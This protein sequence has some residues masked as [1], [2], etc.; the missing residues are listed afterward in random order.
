L[1]DAVEREP[2]RV[3]RASPGWFW[4]WVPSLAAAALAVAL[5]FVWLNNGDL[6]RRLAELEHESALQQADLLR[7][8]E[9]LATL[10]ATDASRV[11]LVAAKT[12]AQPQGRAIYVRNRGSLIFL[13]NNF[14]P[15]PPEKAYEL[16][17]I[18]PT[19]SPVPVAVFKPDAHG[20]A[21]VV[22]PPLPV[23]IEAKA[24]AITVEPEK[25]SPAPTATPILLGAGG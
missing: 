23:G 8:K 13:A 12:P 4:K 5:L 6:R 19:G 16:W 11:T 3:P 7:A 25:G 22:N 15:L 21:T 14:S 24:F 2:R 18:P 9:V 1:L 20:S 17:L 10:T